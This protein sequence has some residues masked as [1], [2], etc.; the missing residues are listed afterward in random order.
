M[1]NFWINGYAVFHDVYDAETIQVLKDEMGHFITNYDME[2]DEP[3]DFETKLNNRK[4]FFLES[5]W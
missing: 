5:A 3:E 4:N 1:K 2:A